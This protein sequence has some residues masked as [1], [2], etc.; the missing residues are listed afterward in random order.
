VSRKLHTLESSSLSDRFC[1][2]GL[3]FLLFGHSGF[4]KV[5][6]KP[7]FAQKSKSR[8]RQWVEGFRSSPEKFEQSTNCRW[9]DSK[10]T[11]LSCV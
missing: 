10:A 5:N 9:W 7:M 2:I 1:V 11:I 6:T 8:P 3:F 4:Y